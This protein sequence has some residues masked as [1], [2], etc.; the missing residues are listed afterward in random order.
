MSVTNRI[1]EKSGRDSGLKPQ[2]LGFRRKFG[3]AV[4]ESS[5][6][7]FSM[8]LAKFS[9]NQT[10]S[11]CSTTPYVRSPKSCLHL[12]IWKYL[13]MYYRGRHDISSPPPLGP[14]AYVSYPVAHAC[15][16]VRVSVQ[17]QVSQT[18]SF[19]MSFSRTIP[20][21][22]GVPIL[23]PYPCVEDWILHLLSGTA[24]VNGMTCAR[25][26]QC[27]DRTQMDRC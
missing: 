5:P 16:T 25:E 13:K 22:T 19:E 7:I 2:K 21:N 12:P 26:G 23:C 3:R 15:V 6:S 11:G 17:R 14:V 18:T 9:V 10:P 8:N 20:D 27:V 24:S 4:L 1:V